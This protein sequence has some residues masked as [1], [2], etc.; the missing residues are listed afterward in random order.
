MTLLDEAKGISS[1]IIAWRRELH[2]IPEIGLILPQT[3]AFV[4]ARLDEMGIA[5]TTFERHSGIVALIGKTPGKTIA[6]RADMDGLRINEESDL[7]YRSQNREGNTDED[8]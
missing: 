3:A 2:K 1:E 5:Y 8:W 7:E 6:L 4:K